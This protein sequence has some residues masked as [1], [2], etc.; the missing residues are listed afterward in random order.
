M[1]APQ[2]PEITWKRQ[3]SGQ[4][5]ARHGFWVYTAWLDARQPRG[6]HWNLEAYPE[7]N[8]DAK[9]NRSGFDSAS[10]AKAAALHTSCYICGRHVP[11]GTLE[12]YHHEKSRN[13]MVHSW[14]CRDTEPCLA[15]RDLIIAR[16]HVQTYER[17]LTEI[18]E[19]KAKVR[20]L[21]TAAL[22]LREHALSTGT[23]EEELYRI[24]H[25]EDR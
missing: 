13:W 17:L 15:E 21:E 8:P 3:R 2:A 7:G 16:T 9:Q 24:E 19:A 5:V 22:K 18:T 25:R 12:P 11:F 1:T 10:T 20:R 6:R 23:T 14:R 4:Y